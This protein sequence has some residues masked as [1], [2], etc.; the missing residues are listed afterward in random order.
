MKKNTVKL[1]VLALALGF[2][3]AANAQD[4]GRKRVAQTNVKELNRLGENYRLQNAENEKVVA[5]LAEKNNWP[6]EVRKDNG[7]YMRLSYVKD[8]KPVYMSTFNEETA[9]TSRVD[10][11][12]PGGSSGLDLTGYFYDNEFDD[13]RVAIGVWDGQYP[14]VTHPEFVG[15][16]SSMDGAANNPQDHPTHVLGTLIAQGIDAQARGMAYEGFGRVANFFNDFSEMAINSASLVLSNH[17]YGLASSDA[18]ITGVYF[19]GFAK[20]VD[21]IAFNA[22][23]YQPVF[24]AGNDGDGTYDN[25]TDRGLAK[26]GITVAAIHKL[27]WVDLTTPQIANFSN[28]GPADDKRVKPDIS[29]AGVNI[30]S[31]LA[32]LDLNPVDY[33]ELSG[34]SMACPSVT[35]ALALVQQHYGQLHTSTDEMMAGIR[36]YMLSSTLRALMAHCATEAGPVGPDPKFGWGVIN[37]EK[38]ADV[39]TKENNGSLLLENILVAGQEYELQV[40]ATGTEPLV[41]TLAWTDPAPNID[42]G[43]GQDQF[44]ESIAIAIVN[45]LDIKV[46]K[47]SEEN[48]PWKLATSNSSPALKGVNNVDNLEKVEVDNPS[49]TYTIKISHKGA[50]L[51]NP[52]NT[53]QPQQ[54]YSLVVTGIGATTDVKDLSKSS[55]S[56]WPNPAHGRLNISIPVAVENGAKA[57][58]YDM[59]GRVV[60]QNAISAADTELNI[61]NLSSGVYFVNLTNGNKNEVKKFIVK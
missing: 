4:A 19:G 17:S 47:G 3:F 50:T 37:A 35:G 58:V 40:E 42:E 14:K 21:V 48:L 11:L 12:H 38:M 9:I 44:G 32:H 49:G 5:E 30:Y 36:N 27:D 8:G 54:V 61:E 13:E 6:L 31:T 16:F 22:P 10:K 24:A 46:V 34:T 52:A 26:N 59:Q 28:W 39:V 29:A 20:K 18:S 57:I 60:L 55:F 41:A 15:R 33:G 45:D 56:V 51:V 23:Y 53:S 7:V 43:N 1:F 2:G 25:L